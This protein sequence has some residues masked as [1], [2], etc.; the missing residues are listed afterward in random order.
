MKH[1]YA[2]CDENILNFSYVY[3]SPALCLSE[4]M[5]AAARLTVIIDMSSIR[6][7]HLN[8]AFSTLL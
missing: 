3:A 5:R 7:A 1:P 4:L 8:R 2:F 6:L